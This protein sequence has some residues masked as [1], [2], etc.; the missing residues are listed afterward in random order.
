MKLFIF[1]LLLIS[2]HCQ[3]QESVSIGI[4]GDISDMQ[5][6]TELGVV[7]MG[8]STDVDEAFR[9][10]IDKAK[11]GD[12][13]ILRASG[14]TGYNEYVYNLGLLNSVETLLINS[15]EKANLPEVGKRLRELEKDPVG[16]LV[17]KNTRTNLPGV[18]AAGDVQDSSYRQAITAAGSGCM[19]AIET[20][21]YLET[22]HV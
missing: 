11:G 1:L 22:L 6:K 9:W 15:R 12:F 14:S 20:E 10:M 7:L 21:R 5:V 4:I 19:A 17:T 13:V 3:G 18:F 2:M 16:Y 8:G